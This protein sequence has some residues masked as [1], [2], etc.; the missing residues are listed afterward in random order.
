MRPEDIVK[1][2]SSLSIKES[3]EEILEIYRAQVFDANIQNRG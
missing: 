3:P 1:L 2:T